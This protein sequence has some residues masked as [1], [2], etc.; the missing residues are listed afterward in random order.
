MRRRRLALVTLL[1]TAGASIGFIG[2]AI[3]SR[4]AGCGCTAVQKAVVFGVIVAVPTGVLGAGIGAIVGAVR[5]LPR[6][7]Q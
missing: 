7:H 2:G 6:E 5:P 4:Q 3:G 1:S